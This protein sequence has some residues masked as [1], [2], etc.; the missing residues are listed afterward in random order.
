MRSNAKFCDV[1]KLEGNGGWDAVMRRMAGEF[2]DYCSFHC[3][4]QY[5]LISPI[6]F[7]ICTNIVLV[8]NFN[9]VTDKICSC[10][11]ISFKIRRRTRTK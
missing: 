1:G 11:K 3:K 10:F 8:F 6:Y 4:S 2:G 5:I 7:R 9:L